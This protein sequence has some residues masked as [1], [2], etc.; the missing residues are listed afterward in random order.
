MFMPKTPLSVTID[1]G[2]LLWLKGRTAGRKKRSL[3]ET[4]D[5]ILTEAR[6]GGVGA[7]APRSVV[8]TIDVAGDDPD[9]ASA[10]AALGALFETSLSRPFLVREAPAGYSA[11]S[12]VPARVKKAA[13]AS[14]RRG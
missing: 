9:L 1:D 2:N 13:G 11:S 4:L 10:D 6:T 3:S 14:K 5:D 12:T 7:D 8:G